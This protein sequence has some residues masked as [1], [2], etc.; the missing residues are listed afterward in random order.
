MKHS[1]QLDK[2]APALVAAQKTI[3][4]AIKSASN[5]HF[6]S[7]YAT[8]ADIWE[9]AKGPLAANGLF[10]SQGTENGDEAGFD[11]VTT[12]LH[13]SGQWVSD[14]VRVPMEKATP[15][16][17]GSALT[18]AKRYGLQGVLG[19][20]AD[21]DDDGN[22]ASGKPVAQ[23]Q[24][25][26]PVKAAKPN[27][28]PPRATGKM[29]CPKCGGECWD[30]RAKKASGEFKASAPDGKCKNKECGGSVWLPKDQNAVTAAAAPYNQGPMDE[31]PDFGPDDD[32]PLP[33]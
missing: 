9:A 4:P 30:N 23:Q 3:G 26:T 29:V 24:A 33:F 2:I 19:I 13:T 18:Y 17:A 21:D 27:G 31:P 28:Q 25:P 8:L 16:G 11:L 6:H 5:A 7:R 22:A 32:P 20:V 10:V 1:E 14:S 12:I 15:Q